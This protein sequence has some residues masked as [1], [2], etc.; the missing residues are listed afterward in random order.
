MIIYNLNIFFSVYGHKVL[1]DFITKKNT[2]NLYKFK[3]DILKMRGEKNFT[4]GSHLS[5]AQMYFQ[6]LIV[7]NF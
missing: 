4:S 3:L 6:K 1:E 7:I 2:E 5:L